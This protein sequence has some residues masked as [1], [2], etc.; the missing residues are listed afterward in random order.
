MNIFKWMEC[1][2][3]FLA[4]GPL[5]KDLFI[6]HH[7]LELRMRSTKMVTGSLEHQEQLVPEWLKQD[8][9]M[10]SKGSC[11]AVTTARRREGETNNTRG[12]TAVLHK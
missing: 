3:G 7:S 8:A 5:I 6:P 1:A 10:G 2:L 12:R 9:G 11:R 4:A